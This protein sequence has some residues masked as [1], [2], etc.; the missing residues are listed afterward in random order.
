MYTEVSGLKT[1][2]ESYEVGRACGEWMKTAYQGWHVQ[3][4]EGRRSRGR[5]RLRRLDRIE[6]DMKKVELKVEDGGR[7]RRSFMGQGKL[8]A[9]LTPESGTRQEDRVCFSW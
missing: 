3:Q 6:R 4:E 8:V 1:G 7:W 9:T 2:E 5:L